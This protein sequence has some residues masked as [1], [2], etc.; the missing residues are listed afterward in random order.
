MSKPSW[1]DAPSWA[2]W[3]AADSTD[4]GTDEYWV[5]FECEPVVMQGNYWYAYEGRWEQ[6]KGFPSRGVDWRNSLEARP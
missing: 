1:F 2:K 5:W 3:L 4:S 6:D